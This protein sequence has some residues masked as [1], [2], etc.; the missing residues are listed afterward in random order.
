MH[1]FKYFKNLIKFVKFGGITTLEITQKKGYESLKGLK[2]VIT[3]GT[4]GIGLTVAKRFIE[5][6][7][8][9]L[10]TG[11]SEQKLTEAKAKIDSPNL[12]TYLWDL[13]DYNQY[14]NHLKNILQK[15][16]SIDVFINNAGILI[17]LNEINDQLE[18]WNTIFNTNL[19]SMYFNTLWICNNLLGKGNLVKVIN[20][21]SMSE[22]IHE[23]DPYNISKSGISS[24]IKGFVKEYAAKGLII[25]AIAPGIVATKMTNLESQTNAYRENNPSKRITIPEEITEFILFISSSSCYYLQGQTIFIDGGESIR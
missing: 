14:N 19:K 7:A 18:D 17:N 1:L 11:R 3:G 15:T 16:G 10:I 8:S 5:E 22:A 12:I 2:I 13:N 9:V 23:V 25:N 21:S 6:G 24:M 20:I 4:S